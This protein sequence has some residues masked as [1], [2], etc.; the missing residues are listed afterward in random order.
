MRETVKLRVSVKIDGEDEIDTELTVAAWNALTDD[1]RYAF[2]REAWDAL[3]ER[4]NGGVEVLTP[5]A[6]EC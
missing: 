6:K 3:A 1:E 2:Y 4:D 5:G